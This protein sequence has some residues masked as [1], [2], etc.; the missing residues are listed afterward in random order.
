LD[1]NEASQRKILQALQDPVGG[2][3]IDL[4]PIDRNLIRYF[5]VNAVPMLGLDVYPE[6]V[7]QHDPILKLFLPFAISSRWC[8]ETMILLFSTNHCRGSGLAADIGL[9]DAEN[10]YLASQQNFMLARTRERISALAN[11]RDSSDKDVVAFLFLALAEYCAG[12]RQIGL[13]HFNA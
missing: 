3:P 13:M 10:H 2:P 11:Y 8:F 6:V 9:L 1:L 4:T 5:A 12:N 7:Q